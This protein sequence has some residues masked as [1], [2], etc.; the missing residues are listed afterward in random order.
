MWPSHAKV[1]V[2]TAERTAS[3]LACEQAP[4][5]GGKKIG[6][7]GKKIRRAKRAVKREKKEFRELRSP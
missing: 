2:R 6:A 7:G 5:E 3:E 4:S 1:S